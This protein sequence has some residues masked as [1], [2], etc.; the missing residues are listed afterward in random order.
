MG[1]VPSTTRRD[2]ART[3]S[4]E[5]ASYQLLRD[6]YKRI[7]ARPGLHFPDASGTC[8]VADC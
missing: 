2:V 3:A 1:A 5:A 4:L 8:D 6:R 7:T